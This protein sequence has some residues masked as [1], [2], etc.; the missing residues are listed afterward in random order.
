MD[1]ASNIK[2]IR[3]VKG[4][5]P[6]MM[7]K[8]LGIEVTNYPKFENRGNQLTY[9]NLE[10]IS[11]ALGVT[12][13]E[14]ITWEDNKESTQEEKQSNKDLQSK[15]R[16]LTIARD[17]AQ[18]YANELKFKA[19]RVYMV[20]YST[21]KTIGEDAKLGTIQIEEED[22]DYVLYS[23]SFTDKELVTIFDII[24]NNYQPLYYMLRDLLQSGL[25]D[26]SSRE[27]E[28]FDKHNKHKINALR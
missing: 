9:N 21:I 3:K 11:N 25:L 27:V 7:A 28:L 22:E 18:G 24:Y 4:I 13:V 14:L 2:A 8:E 12:V 15:I 23:T 19:G 26:I 10:R 16:E 5:T 20:F 1:I 6:T 17:I